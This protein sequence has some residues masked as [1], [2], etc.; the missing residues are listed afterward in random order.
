MKTIWVLAFLALTSCQ[1]QHDR[2]KIVT[3]GPIIL[4]MDT[5]TGQSWL[6][7]PD[8][9]GNSGSWKAVQTEP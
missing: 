6:W 8:Y 2:Y 5:E 3:Q 1:P 4:K 9:S 7:V